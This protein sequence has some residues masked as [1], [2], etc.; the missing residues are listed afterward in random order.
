[1]PISLRL[2]A[3]LEA[4]IAGFGARHGLSKSAVI[5]RSIREFLARHAKPSSFQVYE[6]V[7]RDVDTADA[8]NRRRDSRREAA[9]RRP[10]KLA[11]RKA[12]RRKHAA[13][14][15]RARLALTDAGA[16]PR[17]GARKPA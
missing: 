6:E 4:A 2:P 12:T 1:M 13:R 9:E 8:K 7:M 16:T 10:L 17:R 3:D 5:E 15:A 11:S 14:S